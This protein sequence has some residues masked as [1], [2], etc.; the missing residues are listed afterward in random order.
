MN[1]EIEF[2][3]EEQRILERWFEKLN[4]FWDFKCPICHYEEKNP[5]F[6]LTLGELG[7][8]NSICGNCSHLT[9][10]RL[11]PDEYLLLSELNQKSMLS[12]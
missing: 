8:I 3:R 11:D 7:A 12:D 5:K 2:D 1:D 9:L 10:F 4:R 6:R